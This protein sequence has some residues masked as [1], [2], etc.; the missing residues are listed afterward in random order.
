MRRKK[1]SELDFINFMRI[2][3]EFLESFVEEENLYFYPN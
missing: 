1:L 2:S 3:E